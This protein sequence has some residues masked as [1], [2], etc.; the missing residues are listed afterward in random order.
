M[1]FL[2][3][4]RLFLSTLSLRRATWLRCW[5]LAARDIS[6]HALLAESDVSLM[7]YDT[8]SLIFLSTLSLRRATDGS[9][10]SIEEVSFLSTLSLRRATIRP[11]NLSSMSDISIHALLAESDPKKIG[12]LL[13]AAYFYPRSPCG[14]RQPPRVIRE[15]ATNFYPR[16]PCG[17]RRRNGQNIKRRH[18]NFYPRSPCGERQVG[19]KR[20]LQKLAISIHALL[21]ESDEM[22]LD[23]TAS[24]ITFLS[25]LSLRRATVHYD[26]YNLHCVI[27][28]HALLAESDGRALRQLQLALCHFYPRSPCGERRSNILKTSQYSMYFYPRSPCGERLEHLLIY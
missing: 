3:F 24:R 18:K 19:Q 5:Q 13:R 6:I 25:T 1:C 17:E 12:C 22:K 2:P 27:S 14:E 21:A 26:N 7:L 20:F 16:S 4:G 8:S 23:R 9:Q 15:P 28:I 10:S 11:P